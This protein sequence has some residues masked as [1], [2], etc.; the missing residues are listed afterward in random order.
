M[1]LAIWLPRG[2]FYKA[3]IFMQLPE[4]VLCDIFL[5]LRRC[6]AKDIETYLKPLVYVCVYLIVLIT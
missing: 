1:L 6:P 4:D 5:L 2:S 3:V